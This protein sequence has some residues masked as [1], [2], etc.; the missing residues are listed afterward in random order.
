MSESQY[1]EFVAIDEPL[2][3]KQMAELRSCSSRGRITP[4]SFV[5]HYEWGDL[6]AD[7]VDWMWRY[8]DA[9]VYVANWC[10]C[11]LYMRLPKAALDA[12]T[13]NA[14]KTQTIFSVKQTKTH[15]LLEWGL[16]ESDNYDRF[17]ED[18]G[19]G[20]M[21]RLV[22]LR[23]DLLRGDS[24]PLYLGWLA[25]VSAS[26]V[27]ENAVEPQP[28]AGL[29]R[30]TA[31]Q[32]A[33]TDFLEIDLDLLT[34][35]ALADRQDSTLDGASKAEL[36]PWIAALPAKEKAAMLKLLL[37]GD[38]HQAERKLKLRFLAW[39]REQPPNDKSNE[40]RRTVAELHRLAA[41]AAEV[42]EKQ[43]AVQRRKVEAERQAKRETYL[44]MLATDFDR[45]WQAAGRLI[46]RGIASAYDELTRM[47][48]DLSEAYVLCA[49]RSDFDRRLVQFIAQHG[50]R[51]A[52][53]RRLVDA[54][55][56]KKS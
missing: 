32:H 13:L 18:D 29:S 6:K 27:D 3:A 42:R 10:T 25:G 40:R 53:V 22:G 11:L 31:A 24:R 43:K 12:K 8:F 23:D 14:F 44:R 51:A 37:T 47:L 36:D 39:Q 50:K 33:L 28:P 54:G 5:N 9:H 46:E 56:W 48:I 17:T 26:E 1:Y 41:I 52:L 2:T 30:L 4:T 21:G 15:W 16:D 55:L 20:W 19:Q 49:T 35:A 45:S 38:A 7:P 34:A